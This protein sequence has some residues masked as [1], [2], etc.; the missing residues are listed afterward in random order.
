[1]KISRYAFSS[2][3]HKTV[4]EKQSMLMIFCNYLCWCLRASRIINFHK[5]CEISS[6]MI[7]LPETDSCQHTFYFGH[8]K[9]QTLWGLV[10]I[11]FLEHLTSQ[12]KICYLKHTFPLTAAAR[13]SHLCL[14]KPRFS[15]Q[16]DRFHFELV[17]QT[18][19][20]IGSQPIE[21][22]S[23]T[24][25]SILSPIQ[26]RHE[27]ENHSKK[28]LLK[29]VTHNNIPSSC[30]KNYLVSSVKQVISKK[31]FSDSVI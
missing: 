26:C 20:P 18:S 23:S 25:N 15:R 2:L 27:R 16:L 13:V 7:C 14:T 30:P 8:P 1:M 31:C 17:S 4:N 5:T 28:G 21:A 11:L 22:V 6:C 24:S 10:F 9:E 29:F 3:L 19:V 12:R